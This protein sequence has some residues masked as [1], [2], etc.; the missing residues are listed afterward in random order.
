MVVLSGLPPLLP[1]VDQSILYRTLQNDAGNF[2]LGQ[3]TV[4]SHWQKR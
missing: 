3:A 2:T 1:I 4:Y